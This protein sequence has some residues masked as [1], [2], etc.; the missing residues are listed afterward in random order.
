MTYILNS[1]YTA[2]AS[3]P[4]SNSGKL[5]RTAEVISGFLVLAG[6]VVWLF[7]I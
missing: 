5:P 2:V 6:I 1:H 7:V 4:S 3:R